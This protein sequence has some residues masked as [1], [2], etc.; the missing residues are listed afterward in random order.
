MNLGKKKKKKQAYI[1]QLFK[2]TQIFLFFS[3]I[4][5]IKSSL[6]LWNDKKGLVLWMKSPLLHWWSGCGQLCVWVFKEKGGP[7]QAQ[8]ILADSQASP[9]CGPVFAHSISLNYRS[10]SGRT[11]IPNSVMAL[12][13]H[14]LPN[15]TSKDKW[16]L[17]RFFSSWLAVSHSL[18]SSTT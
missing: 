11:Q 14:A 18:I 1:I 10:I 16:L 4:Y 15:R 12:T 8:I 7:G 17:K 13:Q 5:P 2:K 3:L 6:S 9:E